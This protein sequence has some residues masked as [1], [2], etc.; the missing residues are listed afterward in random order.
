MDLS[1]LCTLASNAYPAI[2]SAISIQEAS[3]LLSYAVLCLPLLLQVC[4]E[5]LLQLAAAKHSV[6]FVPG[7][8]CEGLR[9]MARLSFSFYRPEELQ[10]GV[11]RLAAAL[12]DY[13]AGERHVQ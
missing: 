1:V 6:R 12:A 11:K 13:M 3:H 7:R 2:F 10:E 8:A 5:E 9:H 4:A